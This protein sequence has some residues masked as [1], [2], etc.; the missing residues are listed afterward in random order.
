MLARNDLYLFFNYETAGTPQIRLFL[1]QYISDHYR[2]NYTLIYYYRH[3]LNT[4]R[5]YTLDIPKHSI[6]N[7]AAV[8]GSAYLASALH[9]FTA[10]KKDQFVTSINDVVLNQVFT[11]S[12]SSVRL[13]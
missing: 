6:P 8:E 2:R 3:Q 5:F 12:S 9:D 1:F 11:L 13:Q 4:L 10:P 7:R